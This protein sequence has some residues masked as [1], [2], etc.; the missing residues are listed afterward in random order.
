MSKKN[1]H[2]HAHEAEGE[3][4]VDSAWQRLTFDELTQLTRCQETGHG[5]R[6]QRAPHGR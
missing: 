3:I 4:Y 1:A 5:T 2:L 6:D